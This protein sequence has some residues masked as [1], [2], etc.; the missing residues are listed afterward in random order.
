[1][2]PFATA[3]VTERPR[4]LR[5]RWCAVEAARVYRRGCSAVPGIQVDIDE[6]HHAGLE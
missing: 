5:T 3:S 2:E 6:C 4:A 1:M